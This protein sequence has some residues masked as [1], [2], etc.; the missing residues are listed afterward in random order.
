MKGQ[1]TIC[2]VG[3]LMLSDSPLYTSVGVGSRYAQVRE[4]MFAACGDALRGA[5]IAIGNFESVLYTPRNGRLNEIQ[6]S[7][8][9]EAFADLRHAGFNVLNMANNH[10]LQHGVSAFNTGFE[11]CAHEGIQA[12]G[13]ANERPS[14]VM[15]N[16]IEFVFLSICIHLEWY[17]PNDIVYETD[18]EGMIRR[19]AA[20]RAKHPN[21]VIVLSV[22]WG[23]EF[24]KFPTNAQV[25]LAHR[26]VECGVDILLG[27]HSHVFQGIET[28]MG[29]VIAYSQGNFVSDMIPEICRQ[30]G[31]IRLTVTVDDLGRHVSY[32]MLPFRINDHFSPTPADGA[33]FVDR[34]V[35]LRM[36]LE[37]GITDQQYREAI[38][39]THGQ[40]HRSFTAAFKRNISKYKPSISAQ[41]LLEF[42][43]RKV[44]KKMG[45]VASASHSM[46]PLMLKAVDATKD[47]H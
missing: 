30:T 1:V 47:L 46:D 43:I 12:I 44:K 3:D 42:V 28:Y 37:G 17:S 39:F 41:M 33:W 5:D 23:D 8:P 24:A 16:G 14:M 45:K 9:A 31:I 11:A 32:E 36:V 27:H 15:V 7:C 2:S 21:T 25:Q 40:C 26:F 4:G 6:M 34:Q 13:R 35:S 38:V 10:C 22:H 19:T 20:I 29:A 18:I